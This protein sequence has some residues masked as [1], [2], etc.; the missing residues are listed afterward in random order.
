MRFLKRESSEALSIRLRDG[1]EGA[2]AFR[3]LTRMTKITALATGFS[4]HSPMILAPQEI[5]T[6][7]VS[8]VT[9]NR[10]RLFQVEANAQLMLDVF[11]H[12]RVQGKFALHSFVVMPDHIHVLITP[13]ADVSLE[14]AVQFIKGGFSFRLKSKRDV[15]ER[16]YNESQILESAKFEAC[17]RYIE[18]NPVKAGLCVKAAGYMFSSAR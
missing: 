1:T 6:Y 13:A 3:P 2:G 4:Y 11:Q 10:R 8:A 5:R 14:K 9:A 7:F 15:W 12:Y 16:S 17:K 18:E